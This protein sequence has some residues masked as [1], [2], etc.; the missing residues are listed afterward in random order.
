MN[1]AP[2]MVRTPDLSGFSP[3]APNLRPTTLEFLRSDEQFART[4]RASSDEG[5]GVLALV[6]DGRHRLFMAREL[7]RETVFGRAHR[8]NAQGQWLPYY[9]GL[10][11]V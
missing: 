9:E 8:R 1:S 10:I 2:E 4:G 11:R 7:G 5:F 6:D 3:A